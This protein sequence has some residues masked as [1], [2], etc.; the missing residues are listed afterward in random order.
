MNKLNEFGVIEITKND[1]INI[2]GGVCGICIFAA[3]ITVGV[4]IDKA[5]GEFMKG[6]NNPK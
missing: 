4:A 1:A 3:I 2:K 5:A 6:W